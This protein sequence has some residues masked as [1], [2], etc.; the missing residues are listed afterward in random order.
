MWICIQSV[1]LAGAIFLVLY[2]L[3]D[4]TR[5]P[6][7]T[8]LANHQYPITSTPFPAIGICSANKISRSAVEEF[9]ENL[10]VSIENFPLKYLI[11]S[12][13]TEII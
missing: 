12:R 11:H 2:S 7:F 10:Y 3:Y 5:S 8:S 4:F 1:A 6:T 13:L 9:F